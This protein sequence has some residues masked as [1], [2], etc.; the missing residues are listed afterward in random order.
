M[1]RTRSQAAK[2]SLRKFKALERR[3]AKEFREWTGDEGFRRT[4]GSGGFNKAYKTKVGEKEFSS[5]IM[6]ENAMK[7][8]IEVKAEEGFSLNALLDPDNCKTCKFT[9]WW[10]QTVADGINVNKLP[11]LWFKP[12][13][14]WDWIAL[15]YNGIECLE[16]DS[17]IR[18]II[19]NPYDTPISGEIHRDG[20]RVREEIELPT[21]YMFRWKDIKENIDG[22][23]LFER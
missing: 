8:T 19:I 1:A 11:L 16:I 22:Q 9:E 6:S 10:F 18:R 23:L 2:Y 14:N 5:D 12:I 15:S 21:P 13:P 4:P 17:H 7:F 3:V 20:E